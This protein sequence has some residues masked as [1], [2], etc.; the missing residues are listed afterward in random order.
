MKT[1]TTTRDLAAPAGRWIPMTPQA[2]RLLEAEIDHLVA[3]VGDSQA[4]AWADGISGDPDAPTFVAN[5]EL[6]VQTQRLEKLRSAIANAHVV[7]S[8]GRGIVGS[9]VTVSDADGF[10][11]SYLLVAP[12]QADARAGRIS[13]D[14]PL[15]AA[16]L[17]RRAGDPVEIATAAGTHQLVVLRV[18]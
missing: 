8:D 2:F 14:S 9:H 11:E 16:L 4:T 5:G 6:H 12:G 10:Q 7:Q 3:A 13:T 18:E 1:Q 15:G 17:G